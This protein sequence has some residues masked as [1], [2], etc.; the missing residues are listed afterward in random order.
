LQEKFPGTTGSRNLSLVLL[1]ALPMEEL[2]TNQ[3]FQGGSRT[4]SDNQRRAADKLRD[5]TS[6]AADMARDAASQAR[7]AAGDAA[8]T[9]SGQAKQMMDRQIQTGSEVA[10]QFAKSARIAADE[11]KD[12][13]PAVA[14][15]M[16]GIAGT[17]ENYAGS[18]QGQS[19][20]QILKDASDFTKRRPIVVF[21]L[22]ALAGFLALRGARSA[23]VLASPPTQPN[24]FGED[25]FNAHLGGER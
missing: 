3:E 16:R 7:Q 17:V 15:L 11:I 22:T 4:S 20:D 23:S 24:H 25:P 8:S 6:Q 13:S 18:L 9:V 14:S 19:V 12:E 2:M 5:A 1:F 10:R 21:G